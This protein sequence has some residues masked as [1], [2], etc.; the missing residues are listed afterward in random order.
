[1][2]GSLLDYKA[3]YFSLVNTFDEDEGELENDLTT[4]DD[5]QRGY[6][7]PKTQ[8]DEGKPIATCIHVCSTTGKHSNTTQLTQSSHFSKKN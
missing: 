6:H 3:V 5:E 8:A 2:R 4:V 7:V 1:M